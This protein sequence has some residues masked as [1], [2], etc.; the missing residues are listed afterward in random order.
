M[1]KRSPSGQLGVGTLRERHAAF[2][3]QTASLSDGLSGLAPLGSYEAELL[4]MRLR[5]ATTTV[6]SLDSELHVELIAREIERVRGG[7]MREII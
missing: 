2:S 4:R 6:E 5:S 7:A 1:A 3:A